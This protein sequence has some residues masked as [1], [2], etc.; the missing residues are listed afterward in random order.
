MHECHV[1]EYGQEREGK[2]GRRRGEEE[3]ER[4]KRHTIRGRETPQG[5]GKKREG[6]REDSQGGREEQRRVSVTSR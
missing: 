5:N 3:A 1:N 6:W 2:K 4:E